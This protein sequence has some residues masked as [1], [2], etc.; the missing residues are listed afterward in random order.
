MKEYVSNRTGDLLPASSGKRIIVLNLNLTCIIP[1]MQ[2]YGT[3]F[4]G[5]SWRLDAYTTGEPSPF[6]KKGALDGRF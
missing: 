6:F 5:G 3:V 4:K 1:R 2:E